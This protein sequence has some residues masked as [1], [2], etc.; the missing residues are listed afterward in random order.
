MRRTI[1]ALAILWLGFWVTDT[2]AA[3]A[4]FR[5][6]LLGTSSPTPLPDRFGPS[7]L[8]E[9]GRQKP[10]MAAGWGVPLRPAVLRIPLIKIDVLFLTHYHSDH[11]PGI[12]DFWLTRW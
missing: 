1:F 11:V 9:A 12:P 5:V 7:T 4:D 2:I 6:T 8:I 3:E 10:F